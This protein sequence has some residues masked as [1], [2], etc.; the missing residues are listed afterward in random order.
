M[1]SIANKQNVLIL[2]LL[3]YSLRLYNSYFFDAHDDSLNPYSTGI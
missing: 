2:I 3:E 1:L